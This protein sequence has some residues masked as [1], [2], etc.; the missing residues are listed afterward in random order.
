MKNQR[1]KLWELYGFRDGNDDILSDIGNVGAN[2]RHGMWGFMPYSVSDGTGVINEQFIDFVQKRDKY[3]SKPI[4]GLPFLAECFTECVGNLKETLN[5]VENKKQFYNNLH[6]LQEYLVEQQHSEGSFLLSEQDQ[7]P[8]VERWSLDDKAYSDKLAQG[9]A[10]KL[11]LGQ[12]SYL[13]GGGYGFAYAVSD[14][15][16]LKLTSDLGEADAALIALRNKPKFLADIYSVYKVGDTETNQAFFAIL[17]EY[18][19]NK[20]VE[21]F[22]KIQ[23][24]IAKI[25]PE[26]TYDDMLISIKNRKRFDYNNGVEYAKS[27]LTANPEVDVT[28]EEREAAYTFVMGILNIRQEL[29][30]LGIKSTDYIT[31]KNLGYSDNI[32]KFFDVGGHIEPE[33][34]VGEKNTI[35]LPEEAS[36]TSTGKFDRELADKVAERIQQRNGYKTL[37]YKDAGDHGFAYDIGDNKFL[38]VT[39]DKSEAIESLKIR[40]K[41][42]KHLADIYEVLEIKPKEGS[43]LPH[44]FVIIV[45][46]LRTDPQYFDRMEKRLDY[47]F[48]NLLEIDFNHILDDYIYDRLA[49]DKNKER[50]NNYLAK[51]QEDAKFYY[52]LLAI[53]DEAH[54]NG[55]ESAEH[56][57]SW[58]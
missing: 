46:K 38:K 43:E 27:L 7:I 44:S 28:K 4:K 1:Y 9:V 32:L 37:V 55:I 3:P 18:I 2:E 42:N 33:P 16:V 40:G 50:I 45:E 22:I 25:S 52:G 17:Q 14:K 19:V 36:V 35:M 53:A 5:R 31:N 29:I 24:D 56:F 30:D 11:N 6:A 58:L 26:F 13:G 12:P 47:V 57:K 51:N 15:V 23:S 54:K 10:E 39:S 34:D 20:P 48:V 8:A 49:Y 41:N 21:S